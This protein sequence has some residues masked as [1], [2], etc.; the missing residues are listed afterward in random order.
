MSRCLR[1]WLCLCLFFAAAASASPELSGNT[2]FKF[3]PGNATVRFGA[4]AIV[5]SNDDGRTGTIK[6]QLWA[7]AA[8]YRTGAG[9][10]RGQLLGGYTLEPLAA[11]EVYDRVSESVSAS[12]PPAGGR[13]VLAL[14]VSEYQGR[15]YVI[16]DYRN[17]DTPVQLNPP[18]LFSMSGPWRWQTSPEDGSLQIKVALISH[19][20][21]AATGGLRLSVWATSRAYR[22]GDIRGYELGS[23]DL[24]ALRKGL[25]YNDVDEY[26]DLELPPSGRYY[27][28][29]VL[30]EYDGEDYVIQAFLPS[31]QTHTF[32]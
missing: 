12:L 21:R 3:G 4:D 26:T 9:G 27:I 10:L 5:N 24:G 8:P 7:L 22:G 6:V 31:S 32:D 30:S 14:V 18:Q 16:T 28:N 2:R 19:T 29:L 13:Y 20:R 1:V 23:V 11:G 25:V 17:F 15:Q